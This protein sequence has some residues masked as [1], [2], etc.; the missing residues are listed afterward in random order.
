[1]LLLHFST[2]IQGVPVRG[3][4]VMLWTVVPHLHLFGH[5]LQCLFLDLSV[6]AKAPTQGLFGLLFSQIQSMLDRMV[7]TSD[8]KSTPVNLRLPLSLPSIK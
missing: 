4:H 7:L 6:L 1:M 3:V 8:L 5:P 2:F